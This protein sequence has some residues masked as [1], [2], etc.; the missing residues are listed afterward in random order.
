MTIATEPRP[1]PPPAERR[2]STRIAVPIERPRRSLGLGSRL[3]LLT[4]ATL[5]VTLG[6]VVAY[7]SWDAGRRAE[8]RAREAVQAAPAIF[9]G[10]ADS[11]A[12]TRREQ[13]HSLAEQVGTKALLALAP[14]REAARTFHDSAL[15]YAENLRAGA[16]LLFDA[17]GMLLAR[18]DREPGDQVGR[19][20][21]RVSWVRRPLSTGEASSAFVLEVTRRRTLALVVSAPVAQ[22]QG[23]SARWNGVVAA[24]YPVRDEMAVEIGNL[25]AGEVAFV[26]NVG[27]R[28]GPLD[29][30]LLAATP[31]LARAP[32]ARQLESPEARESIFV[33]GRSFGPFDL[34]A[35]GDSYAAVAS[36]ISTGD[37][38]PI[39][40]FV[41][42]RPRSAA[43]AEFHAL[44]RGVVGVGVAA[45]A[46]S[47][48]V[49]FALARR[50]SGPIEQLAAGAEALRLGRLDIELPRPHGA[51]FESLAGAFGALVAE[52]KEKRALEQVLAH[53][54]HPSSLEVEV[55]SLE[56][57]EAT[58]EPRVGR[59]FANR[60]R[61]RAL[62][63]DGGMGQVFRAH[64]RDLDEEVALKVLRPK[65]L[66]DPD[67]ALQTLRREIKAARA[68]THPNVVRVHDLGEAAGV[69][70]LSME[71]VDGTSLR[72]L[73]RQ[74]GRLGL[75]AGLQIAKQLCRG[76]AAVHAGGLVHGD[77][78]PENV[79]AMPSGVVKLMDFGLA[80]RLGIGDFRPGYATGTPSYMSPEH[81]R[82]AELDEASDLYS[83]GVLMFEIFT[84]RVP[85]EA[86]DVGE[87]LRLHLLAAAPDP[88]GLRPD[89][90]A[91]LA[92]VILQCL[93]K[94]RPERPETARELERSLMRVRT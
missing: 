10:F 22:G 74:E 59:L 92:D 64:D 26:G 58:P 68:I 3:F 39:A 27:S 14:D 49:C 1:E 6:V 62:L 43:L 79:M 18:S 89:M 24:L 75:A 17:E 25:L 28:E 16:V 76:L 45:L 32:V 70:F 52:L 42:A 44:R 37:G 56:E 60:Y 47:L 88:R 90:P 66:G 63:G 55:P 81:A 61:I 85:F 53:R 72:K 40:A 86:D 84:G 29:L 94:S 38:E 30:A 77:L 46:V 87:L 21:S 5:T 65:L 2:S 41:A 80:R 54:K 71:Y 13:V 20:F 83:A 15:E 48:P 93:E 23:A 51:E 33:D 67:R 82:G 19:D 50:F 35:A 36:A 9:K 73:L 57:I 4:A 31:G 34:E 69:R 11:L 91:V 12:S 7:S 78:K 8:R